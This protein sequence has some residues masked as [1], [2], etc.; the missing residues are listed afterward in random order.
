MSRIYDVSINSLVDF[1]HQNNSPERNCSGLLFY[2]ALSCWGIFLG[3]F[4]SLRFLRH[5]PS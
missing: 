2:G 5:V 1:Y 4:A 3:L